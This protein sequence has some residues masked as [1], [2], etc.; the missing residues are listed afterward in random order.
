MRQQ[1]DV[2]SDF[3]ASGYQQALPEFLRYVRDHL[4]RCALF[5]RA[6]AFKQHINRQD[7]A[8]AL[9]SALVL[10]SLLDDGDI[11]DGQARLLPGVTSIHRS[12]SGERLSISELRGVLADADEFERHAIKLTGDAR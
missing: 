4:M 5:L 6:V 10:L 8:E 1:I 12:L 9:R 7:R 3:I 11:S 2:R